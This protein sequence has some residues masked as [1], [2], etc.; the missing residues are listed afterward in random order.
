MPAAVTKKPD[1]LK[2]A[3]KKALF[4]IRTKDGADAGWKSGKSE[5]LKNKTCTRGLFPN[6]NDLIKGGTGCR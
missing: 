4:L 6:Y 1:S 3:W 2:K 5:A